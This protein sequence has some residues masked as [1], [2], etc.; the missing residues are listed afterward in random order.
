MPEGL[1]GAGR[2]VA[3]PARLPDSVLEDARIDDTARG[4]YRGKWLP[5]RDGAPAA[6]HEQVAAHLGELTARGREALR[7]FLSPE[8]LKQNLPAMTVTPAQ[9]ARGEGWTSLETLLP[10]GNW[11]K[12]LIGRAPN[13]VQM[14][15]VLTDLA[16]DQIIDGAHFTRTTSD[17]Q[18]ATD[19]AQAGRDVGGSFAGGPGLDSGAATF[20]AGP[21]ASAAHGRSNTQERSRETTGE[22]TDSYTGS[23]TRYTG[24]VEFQVRRSGHPPISFPDAAQAAFWAKTAEAEA[25]GIGESAVTEELTQRH[26]NGAATGIA[27]QEASERL[28]EILRNSLPEVPGHHRWKWRDSEYTTAFDDPE[29]ADG[30]SAGAQR[31]LTRNEQIDQLVSPQNL[32]NRERDVLA[33]HPL[34]LELVPEP[35]RAHDY[36]AE[37][38]ISA[39]LHDG[40]RVTPEAD[41]TG[42]TTEKLSDSEGG[43]FSRSRNWSFFGG[44]V[45]RAYSALIAMEM[46]T[47]PHGVTHGRSETTSLGRQAGHSS[48]G[49]RGGQLDAD[50][51]VRAEPPQRYRA[52]VELEVSGRYW[53]RTNDMVRHLTIGSPGKHAPEW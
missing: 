51:N 31:K 10:R 12:R 41:Q 23:L 45:F 33:G 5:Q 44:I 34:V 15:A 48:G 53:S 40:A 37:L 28:S 24:R 39:K 50:G 32:L 30:V 14:R 9:A 19:T 52:R 8:K 16:H 21:A 2:G 43:T 4:W 1:E 49:V 42:T 25:A 35:G 6:M 7:D 29:L 36:H 20:G 18:T 26:V 22:T 17:A 38:L 3:M 47:S 13:Q 27:L 11:F 46:L